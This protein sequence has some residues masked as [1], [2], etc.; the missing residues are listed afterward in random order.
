MQPTAATANPPNPPIT[1]TATVQSTT[2]HQRYH[3]TKISENENA[4]GRST[5]PETN[6]THTV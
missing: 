6:V 3:P 1:I 4:A 5:E 2:E